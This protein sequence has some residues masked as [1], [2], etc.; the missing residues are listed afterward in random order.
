[1]LDTLELPL[2]QVLRAEEDQVWVE[3]GVPG[4]EGSYLQHLNRG[5]TRVCIEG[6]ASGA[7][8]IASL[9]AIR[10][11]YK[12]AEPV[13]FV[14]DIMTATDV[15]EMLIVDVQVRELAG[16]PSDFQYAI[17]LEEH[18]PT[19]EP[20]VPPPPPPPPPPDCVSTVEV[21]VVLPTGQTDFT[22]VVVRLQRTDVEGAPPFELTEHDG[23]GLFR[24]EG[25]EAGEYRVTAVRRGS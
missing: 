15:K 19:P 3:H 13:P 23:N 16:R 4:L 12:V 9:E 22:D 8:A 11:L 21:R 6:A 14:A 17:T 20:P 18:V 24:R 25:I 2:V 5:P 10:K 1:M 7:G